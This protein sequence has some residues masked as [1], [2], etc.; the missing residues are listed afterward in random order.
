MEDA[1]VQW[2]KVSEELEGEVLILVLMEDA[3]VRVS[4]CSNGKPRTSLNP[5]FNGR[6][7]STYEA[8]VE[9]MPLGIKS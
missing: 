1:L 8:F 6:C 5:C 2:R 3:L 9:I 4:P 7:T